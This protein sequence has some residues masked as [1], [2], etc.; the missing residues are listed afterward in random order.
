VREFAAFAYLAT[1]LASV[2]LG[3]T[4]YLLR[5]RIRDWLS[6]PWVAAA[7]DLT[8]SNHRLAASYDRVAAALERMP[9]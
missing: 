3:V 7:R 5:N 4:G 8:E 1:L 6:A 9:R 2:G